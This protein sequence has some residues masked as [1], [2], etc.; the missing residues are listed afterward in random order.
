ML[1]RALAYFPSIS[2]FQTYTA[3]AVHEEGAQ[4]IPNGSMAVLRQATAPSEKKHSG[5]ELTRVCNQLCNFFHIHAVRTCT[6]CNL[7]KSALD[8]LFCCCLFSFAGQDFSCPKSKLMQFIYAVATH[9]SGRQL[10]IL[11]SQ[12]I[13][14]QSQKILW[15][16][17]AHHY[18]DDMSQHIQDFLSW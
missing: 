2:Y 13:P 6:V 16:K 1:G 9:Q 18:Q 8:K 17:R 11:P 3:T 5:F 14:H 15:C 12:Q 10:L 4:R 7:I